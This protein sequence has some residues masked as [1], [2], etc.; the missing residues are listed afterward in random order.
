MNRIEIVATF[1]AMKELADTDN[2]PAIKRIIDAV[3]E[4]A[5]TKRKPKSKEDDK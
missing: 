1:S 5:Q 3:L 2:M 4:E